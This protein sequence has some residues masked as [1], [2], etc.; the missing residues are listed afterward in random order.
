M[1]FLILKYISTKREKNARL[2]LEI[3]NKNY[4]L[5]DRT[6]YAKLFCKALSSIKI[7]VVNSIHTQVNQFVAQSW[8]NA[9]RELGYDVQYLLEREPYEL[10]TYQQP[11][12]RALVDFQADLVFHINFAVGD[13]FADSSVRQNLLWIMRHRDYHQGI[14][15]GINY[16]NNMFIAPVIKSWAE[17]WKS[18]GF[19]SDKIIYNSEGIDSARFRGKEDHNYVYDLVIVCNRNIPDLEKTLLTNWI[20]NTTDPA[21]KEAFCTTLKTLLSN[22]EKRVILEE[23]IFYDSILLK[24]LEEIL[25]KNGLKL[26]IESSRNMVNQ[27]KIYLVQV[28]RQREIELLIDSGVT[29]SIA[30]WGRGWSDV[31][32]FRPFCKGVAQHGQE[33]ATIYRNAKISLSNNPEF[34]LHERNFEILA[35]GGFPL[36]KGSGSQ[37]DEYYDSITNY[38]RENKEVVMYYDNE[39]MLNKVKYY[40]D[41]EEERLAIALKGKKVVEENFSNVQVARVMMDRIKSYFAS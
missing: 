15:E 34:T 19:P 21:I 2:N 24:Y 10:N 36:V 6:Y 25:L 30:I 1:V 18:T 12:Y 38:F 39:D 28:L 33:L 14:N 8:V 37:G 23:P 32:K 9:F 35:S 11:L 26:G 20:A 41:H 29:S 40:L 31:E 13:L 16:D 27:I 17:Q 3:V 7:L 4:Q 5:K 22:L